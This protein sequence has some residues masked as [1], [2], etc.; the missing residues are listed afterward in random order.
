MRRY[1]TL[2]F[3]LSLLSLLALSACKTTKMNNNNPKEEKELDSNIIEIETSEGTIKIEL[4][5]NTPQH[6]DNFKKLVKEGFYD[7]LLFHRVIPEFMIQGGD[8]DSKNAAF[9]Q[10]L[11]TGGP[12]YTIPAEIIRNES[13]LP[14]VHIRGM[15][16]AAR[17]GDQMN[18]KKESSG[19][20]FYIVQGKKTDEAFL[21]QVESAR[22]FKYSEEQIRQYKEL[23][24]T[25]HLDGEYT[26]FG[27]VISGLEVVEVISRA[28]ANAA[29]RPNTN[30]RIIKAKI[31]KE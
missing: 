31:V 10:N 7:S 5:D 29:N 6:R 12:G 19:S 20:Q 27:K 21:R 11:G 28:S 22:G 13:G 25:P 15:L 4:F 30:I 17:M 14:N 2:F 26:V 16:A 18:P 8:P 1:T 23:G 3:T 24:G 9:G